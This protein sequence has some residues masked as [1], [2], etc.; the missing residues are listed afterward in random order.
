MENDSDSD[1]SSESEHG[2]DHES[3]LGFDLNEDDQGENL[4]PRLNALVH[5][6][7]DEQW[8]LLSVYGRSVITSY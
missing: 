8:P 3:S 7:N 1:A 4:E 2:S 6:D 5:H